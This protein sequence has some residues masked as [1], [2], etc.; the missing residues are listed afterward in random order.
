MAF[1]K[2]LEASFIGHSLVEAGAV[3]DIN[4]DAAAGGMTPGKNLAAC[5]ADGNLTAL[6]A[7][8]APKAKAS[9]PAAT[10][11]TD[12]GGSGDLA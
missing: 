3:V 12:E 8:K 2:V 10:K 5:D 4:D 11:T 6:E 7:A 9:K 1:Y